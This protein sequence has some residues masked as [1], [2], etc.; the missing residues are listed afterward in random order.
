MAAAPLLN[1]S[2][3]TSTEATGTTS[4]LG[5]PPP[6]RHGAVEFHY[7]PSADTLSAASP[8]AG[9]ATVTTDRDADDAAAGD[10]GISGAA[11]A[12]ATFSSRPVVEAASAVRVLLNLPLFWRDFERRAASWAHRLVLLF[13][14]VYPVTLCV[15]AGF[16]AVGGRWVRDTADANHLPEAQV[17]TYGRYLAA[18]LVVAA[19]AHTLYAFRGVCVENAPML[20]VSVINSLLCVARVASAQLLPTVLNWTLVGVIGAATVFHCVGCAVAWGTKG[21]LGRFVFFAV[22]GAPEIQRMYRQFQ[23]FNAL[24]WW[25]LQLAIMATLSIFFYL[26]N[27][28]NEWWGYVVLAVLLLLAIAMRAALREVIKTEVAFAVRNKGLVLLLLPLYAAL[29]VVVALGIFVDGVLHVKQCDG[30]LWR[31][32]AIIATAWFYAVRV[33]LFVS[34]GACVRN[35]GNGMKKAFAEEPSPLQFVQEEAQMGA[36][37]QLEGFYVPPPPPKR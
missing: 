21:G 8:T 24:S 23:L 12:V 9:A 19:I 35:F 5:P 29:P 6:A 2:Q 10:A 15:Y 3:P 36:G 18:Q 17:T 11:A 7:S 33:A 4:S 16:A 28:K 34:V 26:T 32:T 31:N 30:C 13:S 20:L 37:N 22:G 14:I 1:S 25:D 27:A